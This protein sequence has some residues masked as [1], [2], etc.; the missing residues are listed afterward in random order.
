MEQLVLLII[1]TVH[2]NPSQVNLS[3]YAQ[4]ESELRNRGREVKEFASNH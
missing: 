2:Y 1:L 4:E 3:R